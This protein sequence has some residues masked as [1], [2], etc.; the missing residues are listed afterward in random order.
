MSLNPEERRRTSAEL[1]A[2][3]RLSG[4]ETDRLAEQL[5]FT[6][7]RLENTL[8]LDGRSAPVDVWLLRDCLEDL[9]RA[10]GASPAPYSVLTDRA[11]RAAAVWF[12]LPPRSRP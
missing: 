8:A 6:A 5:G 11:R 12:P 4:A 2:N 9:V 10:R 1:R 7:E 3:L